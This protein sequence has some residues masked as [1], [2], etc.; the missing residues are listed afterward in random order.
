[1]I[2]TN[3]DDMNP[4]IYSYV[5]DKLFEA[6]ALDVFY[7]NIMM[8]KNRPALKL[9]VLCKKHDSSNIENIILNETTTLG[10]RKYEVERSIL[11]RDFEKV[12]TLLGEV[13]IKLAIKDNEVIKYAPEFEEC[14]KIA[15][16]ENIPLKQVYEMILRNI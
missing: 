13:T 6:N 12:Q 4:E 2:E 5:M 15:I 16:K 1:M 11:D 8:K 10:I 7:T 9:S 3:I 14:K